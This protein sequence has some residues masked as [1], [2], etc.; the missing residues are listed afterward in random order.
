[1]RDFSGVLNLVK[2]KD[3]RECSSELVEL[4][5]LSNSQGRSTCYSDRM[6]YFSVSHSQMLQGCLC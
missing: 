2:N 6:R 3:F 4:V 5:S 1:M